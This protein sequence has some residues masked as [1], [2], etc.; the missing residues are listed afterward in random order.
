MLFPACVRPALVRGACIVSLVVAAGAGWSA[1]ADATT[2]T[3]LFEATVPLADRSAAGQAEALQEAMRQVL[4]RVTGQ[5]NAGYEPALTPL[6]DD[7]RRYVQQF[8]VVGTNQFFVGFDGARLERSIAA[9]GQPLW[10][11]ERPG[12]LVW[13]ATEEGARRAIIDAQSDSDLKR[14]VDRIATLR[15]VPLIWPGSASGRGFNDVWN[16]SPDSLGATAA[17]HGADAVLVG[18]ASR[19][20]A[21]GWR[22]R[23]T[24]L[25]G[26]ENSAWSGSI[27]E[28]VHGAA[29]KFAGVFA[30]GGGQGDTP[31]VISVSGIGDLG[32]YA[33]VTSYLESLTLIRALSV[34]ELAGD[35]VVYRAQ[36]RGDASRL[37]RAIELGNRLASTQDGGD[38][39]LSTALSYRY[40]P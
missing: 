13:L 1:K 14:A 2:V 8:R 39:A 29:D 9:T 26:E 5:R 4:V 17:E 32:A 33:Q 7:A 15:G 22:V 35:T 21:G 18:R 25:Y 12:T 3:H 11:H 36:V 23:W 30:A 24:L 37:A 6:I 16:G 10:G 40:R 20:A 27:D 28:G 31:V 19:S 38:P 34:D